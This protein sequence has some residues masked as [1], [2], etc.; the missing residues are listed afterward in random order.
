MS[1]LGVGVRPLHSADHLEGGVEADS[2]KGLEEA[3]ASLSVV[4]VEGKRAFDE[5]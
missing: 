1:P 3:F 5:V 2:F 4:A